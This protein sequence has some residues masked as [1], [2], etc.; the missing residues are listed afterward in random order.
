LLQFT[1]GT[2]E[3]A[4]HAV[5][6]ALRAGARERALAIAEN[7]CSNGAEHFVLLTLAAQSEIARGKP[8][9]A[10]PLALRAR[11]LS[12]RNDEVLNTLG[13]AFAAVGRYREALSAF[14]VALRAAPRAWPVRFNKAAALEELQKFGPARTEFERVLD[15]QPQ[16][17]DSLARLASLAVQRG[18]TAEG[19]RRAGQAVRIDPS[20]RWARLALAAAD[21]QDGQFEA[22]RAA[23]EC[24][25]L[26]SDP[27]PKRG[28]VA[29][30][31][32]GDALDGLGRTGEAF[33][34]YLRARETLL[35]LGGPGASGVSQITSTGCKRAHGKRPAT[36][37]RHR[38]PARMCLLSDSPA[39]GRP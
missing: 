21:I 33:A 22:A 17:T 32:M 27:D 26:R 23:I 36:P 4:L 7:A 30:S 18:D 1:N 39:R 31:L 20:H 25:A 5:D 13:V 11:S 24:S 14:E 10:I 6:A 2:T 15:A 19:R 12:P 16:H 38:G 29:Q 34:C 3:Q 35:A 28:Y 37:G 9:K 8:D